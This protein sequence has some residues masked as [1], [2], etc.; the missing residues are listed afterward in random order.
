[1]SDVTSPVDLVTAQQQS[2]IQKT[3]G[4]L[5]GKAR[6]AGHR[7]RVMDIVFWHEKRG[8]SPDEIVASIFPNLTLA[9]VYAALS[10]YHD[11]RQEIEDQFERED[12][13]VRETKARYPSKLEEKTV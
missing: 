1:M 7:V 5:G 13:V 6:I 10:Y 2:H 11:H 4:I 8:R 12:D 3:P 9:D